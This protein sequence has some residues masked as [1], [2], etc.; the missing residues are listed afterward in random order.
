M[1]EKTS[2]GSDWID[3][4]HHSSKK[5]NCS[6]V[7]LAFTHKLLPECRTILILDFPLC[8]LCC[9]ASPGLR[10]LLR[11]P[12]FYSSPPIFSMEQATLATAQPLA[13]VGPGPGPGPAASVF[14]LCFQ[15]L[16]A[17]AL[18]FAATFFTIGET[19]PF[20]VWVAG[21]LAYFFVC[22]HSAGVPPC[23]DSLPLKLI[24]LL[25]IFAGNIFGQDTS[26]IVDSVLISLCLYYGKHQSVRF[27]PFFSSGMLIQH[28]SNHGEHG[29]RLGNFEAG[30]SQ[31]CR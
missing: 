16:T 1:Q 19:T 22:H 24:W 10:L 21:L 2:R 26:G 31:G 5:I 14:T 8:W 30:S 4:I 29:R 15:L 27:F 7:L 23:V 6:L 28:N 13:L 11:D 25:S 3:F 20:T 12:N 18:F 17:F 9:L